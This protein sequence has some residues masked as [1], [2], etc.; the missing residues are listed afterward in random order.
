MAL[1]GKSVLAL[2]L[3]SDRVDVAEALLRQFHAVGNMAR[4]GAIEIEGKHRGRAALLDPAYQPA[5]RR[6]TGFRPEQA[7][8]GADDGIA[9]FGH[10]DDVAYQILATPGN[11]QRA[12]PQPVDEIDL[13]HRID[14]QS[15]GQPELVDAAADVA[16]AIFKQ[17]EIFLH[18]LGVDAPRDL[19]IDRH[20]GDRDRRAQGVVAIPRLDAPD[21]AVPFE[22]VLVGIADHA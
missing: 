2:S 13:L 12:A 10:R 6:V 9:D 19:L 7:G 4:L 18:P 14:A 22:H 11:R 16:I 8:L 5:E 15:A 1:A 20:R 21:H 17:V 3:R